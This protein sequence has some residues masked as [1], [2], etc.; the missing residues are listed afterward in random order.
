M[1]KYGA[2]SSL[3]ALKRVKQARANER[4]TYAMPAIPI[5]F[6]R[7]LAEPSDTSATRQALPAQWT[8]IVQTRYSISTSLLTR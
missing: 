2:R 8:W 7:R 3:G 5:R 1:T 6:Y 4:R